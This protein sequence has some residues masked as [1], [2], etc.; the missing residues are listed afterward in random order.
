VSGSRLMRSAG[1]RREGAKAIK[2]RLRSSFESYNGFAQ[3]F[4]ELA[5]VL[6]KRITFVEDHEGANGI[7]PA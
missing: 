3:A 5:V 7:A 6:K 1:R 2:Y 4:D